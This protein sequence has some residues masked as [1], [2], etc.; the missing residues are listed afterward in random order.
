MRA[1][2]RNGP[3]ATYALDGAVEAV[4]RFGAR[5]G[6]GLGGG[7]RD[8]GHSIGSPMVLPVP[9]RCRLYSAILARVMGLDLEALGDHHRDRAETVARLVGVLV[10]RLGDWRLARGAGGREWP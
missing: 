2:I 8:R 5:D 10:P 9:A 7:V 4:P 6:G 3:V 1:S